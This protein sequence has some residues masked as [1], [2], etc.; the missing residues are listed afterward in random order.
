MTR[1][2]GT[3]LLCGLILLASAIGARADKRVAL[4]VGVSAYQNAPMLPNPARDARAMA[5]M[6]Q[7]SGFDVVSAL[8]DT[9]NLQF[10]RAIRQ[11]ED[12]ASGADIAVIYFAGHGIEIHGVNYLVPADAKLASDRD[13]DDE[14]I[15]LDRLLTSLDGAKKLRLV[16]LDACRDDPFVRKMQQQRSAA[17][18]GVYSGLATVEP[19]TSNTLIAYAAKSGASADDGQTDHSPFT[20]A[21][22]NNLFAPGLDVRLALGRVRDEVLKATANRQEPF[23]YGSLGG[24]NIAIVPT[25]E[26]PPQA[27]TDQ[28]GERGD[29]VRV[30]RIGTKRAWQKFLEQYPNGFYADLARESLAA[31]E[32][33]EQAEKDRLVQELAERE[34][35]A[36]EQAEKDRL[37]KLT[38][39]PKPSP[40]PPGTASQPAPPPSA[41]LPAQASASPAPPAPDSLVPISDPVTLNEFRDRLYELNF[42]PGPLAGPFTDSTRDAI[43]KFQQ[44]INLPQTGIAT[45]GLLQRLRE[46]GDLKPWGAIVFSKDT[47]KWG[48]SWNETTRKAAVEAARKSCGDAKSCSV[49]ISFF[50]TNCGVFAYSTT[51][52][53]IMARESVSAAKV[54]ALAECGKHGKSCAVVTSGCADSAQD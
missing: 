21:L 29:Y 27:A 53:A 24:A 12:A 44:Q 8:Y 51:G 39:P 36:K 9:G 50:G 42:D 14:A 35:I 4:V 47:G 22:L 43:R 16:I 13:A 46:L 3:V 40:A 32:R 45:M 37:A 10:K 38:P 15:T 54:A 34:R 2:V 7:K 1:A 6:F 11:F 30:E 49:E 20:A 23:V 26:Q 48:K 28:E 52:W 19:T 33:A 17:L 5:A 31:I 41:P 25:P 18:R